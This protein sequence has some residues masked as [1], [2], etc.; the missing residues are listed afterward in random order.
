MIKAVLFD[1]DG[2][3]IDSF[4]SNLGF[5]QNVFR[6]AGYKRLPSRTWYAKSFHLTMTHTIAA[7]AGEVSLA[8]L[9]R[10]YDLGNKLYSQ[11]EKFTLIPYST[12]V[13]KKLSKLY[14]L[15]VVT[16]RQKTGLADYFT[17]AHTKQ[18]FTVGIH[19]ELVQNP[20][21]HPE[22]LLLACKYLRIKPFEAVYVGDVHTDV[23]AA[24]AAGMPIIA[25]SKKRS[26]GADRRTV[27][28]RKLPQ[29]IAE[30]DKM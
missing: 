23:A 29:L 18:Y 8:E 30:I 2:V 3:L 21:P 20:K 28:F 19:R 12:G 7:F 25:F 11:R 5:F 4:E 16:N 22:P 14:R 10:L 1:V 9:Q 17:A 6:Q 26:L 15:G 27:D 24:R 13:L